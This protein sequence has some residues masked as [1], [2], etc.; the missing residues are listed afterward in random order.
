M[1]GTNTI[2]TIDTDDVTVRLHCEHDDDHATFKVEHDGRDVT[3]YLL[4]TV[5]ELSRFA[6]NVAAE[7]ARFAVAQVEAA[8][9]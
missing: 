3:V 1:N 9:T 2:V 4:G 8:T 6:A 5:D 7:V